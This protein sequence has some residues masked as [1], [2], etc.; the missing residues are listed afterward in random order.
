M[1]ISRFFA[2]FVIV[3]A[4]VSGYSQVPTKPDEDDVIRVDS[5]LIV[6]PV[7]V[8]DAK[9]NAILGLKASD[10][11][12]TEN[13]RK[14]A[15]ESVGTAADVPL[16]IALLFDISATTSPMFRFQLETAAK[17]LRDVMRPQDNAAIFSIGSK[18]VLV[19]ARANADEA[20]AALGK[21]EATKE[22]TAFYDTVAAAAKYLRENAAEG[23]RRVIL[24][25]SDGED[26]N[27]EQV[28]K[29]IQTGYRKA[30]EK[31]NT[32]DSKSL[33]QMTVKL[34][35]DASRAERQR[36]G[37]LLQDADAVFYSIN[38]GGSS[39]H[40]N[41]ISVFGQENMQI[42]ADA[43]GGTAFLP[44]FS[45]IDT[46]DD[47]LNNANRRK[48]SEVLDRIFTQLAN[49]LRSQYLIQYYTDADGPADRF[50]PIA[51]S[52]AGRSDARVRSRK[53][54][55]LRGQ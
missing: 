29:A 25:I 54:F 10:F 36:V 4:F 26:T 23:S 44:R 37:R 12:L 31:I 32:L 8:T 51:V 42:F 1:S 40:L 24:V 43:T 49:E 55:Y 2:V 30:G 9:G 50:V 47:Y 53:G 38:P 5:R 7:S 11:V 16:E 20:V 34:R 6:I 33:Y 3:A 22:Y 17:F 19:S 39:F 13:G 18:P 27:S 14:Q 48:N 46:K 28:R 41:S 15:I 35:D 52:V 45:P 21:I